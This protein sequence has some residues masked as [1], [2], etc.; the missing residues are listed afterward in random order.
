MPGTGY[1]P[2]RTNGLDRPVLRYSSNLRV[3]FKI[4]INGSIFGT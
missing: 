2:D 3:C 4:L 1:G